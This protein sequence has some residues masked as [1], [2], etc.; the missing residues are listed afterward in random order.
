MAEA[1]RTRTG[2]EAQPGNDG[3]RG[4]IEAFEPAE[5]RPWR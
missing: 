3:G 2:P 4:H 1:S 5:V